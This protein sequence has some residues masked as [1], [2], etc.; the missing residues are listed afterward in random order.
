[1]GDYCFSA[2][3]RRV[4]R[5]AL[6]IIGSRIAYHLH[7]RI[8]ARHAGDPRIAFPPTLALL[9]TIRLQSQV[10]YAGASNSRHRRVRRELAVRRGRREMATKTLN[11]A[12]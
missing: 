3:F 1:M 6:R 10:V 2:C 11:P 12:L 8:V 9:Q 4:T 7:V 5:Q